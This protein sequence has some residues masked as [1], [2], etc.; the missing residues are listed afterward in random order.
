MHKTL[1]EV[2]DKD[3]NVR[4]GNSVIINLD[5]GKYVEFDKG[6]LGASSTFQSDFTTL[7]K[8][9]KQTG[10]KNVKVQN[11]NRQ[12]LFRPRTADKLQIRSSNYVPK[13]LSHFKVSDTT[14]LGYIAMNQQ[15]EITRIVV[16][17]AAASAEDIGL[18]I[19]RTIGKYGN[20]IILFGNDKPALKAVAIASYEGLKAQT[21]SLLD[22]V[23]I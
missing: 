23:H 10:F 17:D 20:N 9:A 6:Q 15:N 14:K 13:F 1:L 4:V 21:V 7:Q 3:P 2:F 8:Y 11:F 12:E 18:M 5:S 16:L 22:V 19:E